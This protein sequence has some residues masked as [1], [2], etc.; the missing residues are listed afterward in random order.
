MIYLRIPWYLCNIIEVWP[1]RL[2]GS[3][4]YTYTGDPTWTSGIFKKENIKGATRGEY[5]TENLCFLM[6]S[7][8]FTPFP[9]PR[10]MITRPRCLDMYVCIYIYIQASELIIIILY[11]YNGR[12]RPVDIVTRRVPLQGGGSDHCRRFV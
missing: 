12:N 8:T 2:V 5:N 10:S 9:S 1:P 7:Y 4:L 11:T 3:T 6:L